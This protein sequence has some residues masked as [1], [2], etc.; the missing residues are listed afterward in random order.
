MSD[1]TRTLEPLPAGTRRFT[2]PELAAAGFLARYSGQTRE[3]YTLDL[4]LLFDWCARMGLD[5]LDDVQR[6]HL[7]LYARYLEHER[8]NCPKTVHRRL[9]TVRGFYRIASL[10]GYIDKSPAEHIRM[11]R[12]FADET[13]TLGLDRME[14]GALVAAARAS[15]PTDAAL[16]TMLGLLGLRVGEACAVRIGDLAG[17]E[18]GHRV[19]RLVGKGGKPATIP[20]PV[21][22]ART[23]DLAAGE[24]S[25]GEYLLVRVDGRPLDRNAAARIVARLCRK[26]GIRKHI[27][28]HSLRHSFVTAAL[29]AGV[30]LR[31]VQIAARHSDPRITSRYDRGRGNLDRHANYIVASFIAGAA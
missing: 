8:R 28:P 14:L 6:P 19:L 18:R 30:P 15:T 26:V 1:A 5:V 7:E 22:V 12:I 23:L 21:P 10:D 13:R 29:D 17:V 16:I 24:R 9:S 20:L 31:D 3:H 4:R 2:R 25:H 27:T 11:P